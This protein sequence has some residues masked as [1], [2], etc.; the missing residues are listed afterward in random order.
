MDQVYM[1]SIKIKKLFGKTLGNF[2]TFVRLK[3]EIF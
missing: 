3:I 2:K 1:L